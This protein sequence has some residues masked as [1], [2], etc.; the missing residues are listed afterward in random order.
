MSKVGYIAICVVLFL[1]GYWSGQ[2]PTDEELLNNQAKEAVALDLG[3]VARGYEAVYNLCEE[4]Y[5]TGLKGDWD[6]AIRLNGQIDAKLEE[7][8]TIISKYETTAL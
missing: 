2:Q 4:K 8:G 6:T 5:Q 7:L 1:V 3:A